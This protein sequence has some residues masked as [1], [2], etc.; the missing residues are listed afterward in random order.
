MKYILAL[1]FMVNPAITVDSIHD[2]QSCHIKEDIDDDREGNRCE[3]HSNSQ[4]SNRFLVMHNVL[5]LYCA[6]V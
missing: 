1:K 2:F 3:K 6:R 4:P 5:F